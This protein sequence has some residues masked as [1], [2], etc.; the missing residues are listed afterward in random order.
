MDGK[1]EGKKKRHPSGKFGELPLTLLLISVALLHRIAFL[2]S[3]EDRDWGFSIFYEGDSEKFYQFAC[4]LNRGELYDGGIPFHPPG[5]PFILAIIYRVLGVD[6]STHPLPNLQIKLI[7]ILLGSL[8]IGLIY[9]LARPY[10]GRLIALLTALACTYH[11]GLYVFSV[12]PV[13]E[14]AYLLCLLI[15][16]LLWTRITD[17]FEQYLAGGNRI[18]SR[19]IVTAAGL[20][21]SLGLLAL[22]RAE[23]MLIGLLLLAFFAGIMLWKR[24]S[25][26]GS[27]LPV[28]QTMNNR[29]GLITL[30]LI[31]AGWLIVI[32]PWTL[33]NHQH[34]T[35]INRQ[36]SQRLAQ[37]LPTFV[38][39]T[40]YGPLNLALANNPSADGTFSRAILES[41]QG[42]DLNLFHPPH[43]HLFLHGDETAWRFATDQPG[44]FTRLALNKWKLM[45]GVLRQGWTQWNLPAGLS[46][47]RRPID[48]FV[49]HA[50]ILP[51]IL[52]PLMLI[53]LVQCLRAG[54]RPRR[55]AL[56]VLLLTVHTLIV[57]G[58][59]FGYRRLGLICLP[60]W[61]SLAVVGVSEIT[62]WIAL[63]LGNNRG[64]PFY[65]LDLSRL[66]I[67]LICCVVL[68][69][70]G[71]EIWG[72]TCVR[73]YKA[74]G[75]AMSGTSRLN[76]DE[77]MYL[78]PLP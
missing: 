41:N 44:R 19:G 17:R 20:G 76:P 14:T 13:S 49:P 15:S 62:R 12:A 78:D 27:G 37:P 66:R 67:G 5:W 39:I 35:N 10:L 53:G 29:D 11:F 6:S 25:R 34:L 22:I 77:T 55:W 71:A 7:M 52:V 61:L 68:V 24:Y 45:F 54:G 58:L 69:L 16:L 60:F 57:T 4:A 46:G 30:C 75:S 28:S 32:A 33:R 21:I 59:F 48:I 23:G 36:Y 1:M 9:R 31:I 3:N 73:R 70:L 47:V 72:A 2:F 8:V 42:S 50:T 65:K 56:M 74:V 18:D 43:L 64:L 40:A 38:P 51:W 63:S 26:S